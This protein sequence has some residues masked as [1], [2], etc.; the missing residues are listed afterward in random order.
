MLVLELHPRLAWTSICLV[1]GTGPGW[2]SASVLDSGLMH[3]EGGDPQ[4]DFLE[5]ALCAQ[6]S[7][8]DT[9]TDHWVLGQRGSSP[10]GCRRL[11]LFEATPIQKKITGDLHKAT[12]NNAMSYAEYQI[13]KYSWTQRI[14]NPEMKG[15]IDSGILTTSPRVNILGSH[16][17]NRNNIHFTAK[18]SSWCPWFH[19]QCP[20]STETSLLLGGRASPKPFNMYLCCRRNNLTDGG[21]GSMDSL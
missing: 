17:L 2:A 5:P 16:K 7:M 12:Q 20:K 3:A 13:K 6:G 10:L 9:E 14:L 11:N 15:Q 1:W 18:S 19:N 21:S 4:R 8:V